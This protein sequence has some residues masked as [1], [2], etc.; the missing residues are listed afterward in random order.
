[1]AVLYQKD[2]NMESNNTNI[3]AQFNAIPAFSFAERDRRWALANLFMDNNDLDAM[4]IVGEHEDSGPVGYSYDTWFT[5]TRP[6]TTVLL[7]KNGVPLVLLPAPMF[8]LDH[9]KAGS[10][11]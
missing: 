2:N 7:P 9:M 6:G 11:A 10:D 4:L 1:M 5:N 3:T 8:V